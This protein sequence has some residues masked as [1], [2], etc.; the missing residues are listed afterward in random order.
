MGG[1]LEK[2]VEELSADLN[3]A[4]A[5][6]VL[7]LGVA[8][9]LG[10][11]IVSASMVIWLERGDPIAWAVDALTFH[12]LGDPLPPYRSCPILCTGS[13]RWCRPPMPS[14]RCAGPS[15]RGRA[16][17]S[18][19]ASSPRLTAF[20]AVLLPMSALVL[21]W[22]LRKAARDDSLGQA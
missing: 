22:A 17:E 10:L 20:A 11:G 12:G 14:R 1:G 8:A 18:T 21:R 9:Y 7:A 15:F 4:S 2:L 16:P 6:A 19:W 5:L 3:A 13:L